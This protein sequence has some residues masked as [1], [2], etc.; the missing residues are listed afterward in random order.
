MKNLR[1]KN[2]IASVLG[3][4]LLVTIAVG[5]LGYQATQRSV[6]M[7]E[8]LTLRAARQQ[9]TIASRA[10]RMESNR[11]QILQR[12]STIRIARMR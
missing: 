5:A 4:L 9:L 12:C 11:S 8:N 2:L 10:F 1:I 3:A 6:D 7:L